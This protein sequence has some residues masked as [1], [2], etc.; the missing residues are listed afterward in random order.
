M[1][2]EITNRQKAGNYVLTL[3]PL[4]FQIGANILNGLTPEQ[5][6]VKLA[7]QNKQPLRTYKAY[8]TMVAEGINK[9]TGGHLKGVGAG[10]RATITRN[11]NKK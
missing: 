10:K 1:S 11:K 9:A 6:A 3:S 7:K 4:K 5:A 2:K 8:A